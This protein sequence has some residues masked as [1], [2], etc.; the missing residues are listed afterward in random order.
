MT[1]HLNDKININF[2]EIQKYFFYHD[3]CMVN[4][5]HNYGNEKYMMLQ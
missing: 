3:F 1:C 4:V 5:N 2:V